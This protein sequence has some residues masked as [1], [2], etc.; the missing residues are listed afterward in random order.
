ME[1]IQYGLRVFR[2][3]S[4]L[5][6]YVVK[7]LL[8]SAVLFVVVLVAIYFLVVPP[9][10]R[11]I[12]TWNLPNWAGFISGPLFFILF[13]IFGSS[14]LFLTI[15]S[16]ANSF[17][18]EKLSYEVEKD[19]KGE[20]P[21]QSVGIGRSLLDTAQR[22]GFTLLMA[23]LALGCGWTFFGIIGILL[24]GTLGLYDYTAAYYSRRGILFKGQHGY[25]WKLKGRWPFMLGAGLLT[26]L[27][28]VNVIMLPAL[29]AA[30]THMAWK[31]EQSA[32][33]QG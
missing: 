12:D 1:H 24:A 29:V 5:R 6:R 18:W 9:I 14:F 8:L 2:E 20:A 26:L 13:V 17:L 33:T 4:R 11:W 22:L 16:T 31:T 15:A 27:P 10:D 7:P 30:G 3:G 19:L 23:L 28:F 32:A 25:V 21:M